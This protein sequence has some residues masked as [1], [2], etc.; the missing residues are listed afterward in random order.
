MEQQVPSKIYRGRQSTRRAREGRSI[1]LRMNHTDT[2][3][4]Q[5]RSLQILQ[6]NLAKKRE[7]RD[8]ILN[9]KQS[10]EYT[11][12]LLQEPC[13]IYKQNIPLLHQSWTAI[14]PMQLTN[15]PRAAIY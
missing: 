10:Q 7:M 8:S 9:D 5:S 6:Y 12:L 4:H 11:L 13:R 15:N 1:L 3:H 2:N 14:E